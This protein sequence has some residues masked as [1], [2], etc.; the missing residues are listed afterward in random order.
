[1]GV[2]RRTLATAIALILG[3]G[4]TAGAAPS[5]VRPLK[6]V[7]TWVAYYGAA[8]EAAADLAKFDVVV[9]DPIHHPPL[10]AVKRHGAL[11]LMYLSLAEVNVNHPEYATVGQEPWVLGPN[12]RWPEARGLDVRAAGYERWLLD[13]LVPRALA[14]PVNGLFL[15]TADSA[16]ELERVEP[17]RFGGAMA[18]LE[19]VLVAL[20]RARPGALLVLNGGLPLAER[21]ATIL[22][23]V[24]VESVWTEYD[25]AGKAYRPRAE[26]DA[27]QRVTLARRVSDLGLPVLTLEYA[28]PEQGPWV[29]RL[30]GLA[31][32]EGF[33]PYV[34]MIGLGRVFTHTLPR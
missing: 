7:K 19:R 13:R 28:P 11:V 32:G 18:S 20:R 3:S 26:D 33:V 14:A 8:A 6:G 15:D 22:D 16:L 30:I 21:L 29:R 5:G 24:A 31:R 12:P 23:G 27:R 1:V 10:Q 4:S 2:V 34:S 25:F 9:L 17:G